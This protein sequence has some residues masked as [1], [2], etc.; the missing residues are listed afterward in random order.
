MATA[1]HSRTIR[2]A[3]AL[4]ALLGLAAPLL[5][6]L[7]EASVAHVT[8]AEHGEVVDGDARL[9]SPTAEHSHD[10]AVLLAVEALPGAAHGH[11]HCA[12][13]A[14]ARERAVALRSASL[15]ERPQAQGLSA[16]APEDAP[17]PA[18]IA[19]YLLAPKSS[20]PA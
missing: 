9:S 14:Q 16:P 13:A 10:A 6:S 3:A 8:C 18:A 15:T 7:H 20:P 2:A 11:D 19:L 1:P 4:L 17:R 5:G 12:L